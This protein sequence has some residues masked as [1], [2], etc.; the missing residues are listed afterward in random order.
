MIPGLS[1]EDDRKGSES[2]WQEWKKGQECPKSGAETE[3]GS[4][5]GRTK[6]CSVL[7]SEIKI[8]SLEGLCRLF[9]AVSES[10]LSV[11]RKM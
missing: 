1:Q 3:R 11:H 9:L 5:T 2:G 8:S 10:M 4:T 7:V 6:F